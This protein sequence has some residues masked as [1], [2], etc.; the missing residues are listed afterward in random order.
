VA[1]RTAEERAA[2]RE[3]GVDR[4]GLPTARALGVNPRHVRVL[5]PSLSVSDSERLSRAL[6][7]TFRAAVVA[8]APL[9]GSSLAGRSPDT[10]GVPATVDRVT[11]GEP[12]QGVDSVGRRG[13][14]PPSV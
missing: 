11:E 8:G 6:T 14:D 4:Y 1:R 3:L 12:P 7:S 13:H 9:D 10:R 2:A 5:Y